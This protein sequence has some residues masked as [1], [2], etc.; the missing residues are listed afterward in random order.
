MGAR[1]TW[2]GLC[3]CDRLIVLPANSFNFLSIPFRDCT[4]RRGFNGA[5]AGPNGGVAQA[6]DSEVR[7][8]PLFIMSW[9]TPSVLTSDNPFAT[10]VTTFSY[11]YSSP[12]SMRLS[13]QSWVKLPKVLQEKTALARSQTHPNTNPIGMARLRQW[14]MAMIHPD[15]LLQVFPRGG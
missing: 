8:S 14:I 11:P 2:R 13:W 10:L 12:Y 9:L 5:Q 6:F 1:V 3:Q 7:T 15:R 4:Q